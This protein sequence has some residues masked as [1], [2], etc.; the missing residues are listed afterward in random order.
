[1]GHRPRI[2]ICEPDT[3]LSEQ[4]FR[5]LDAA[6]FWV[7][8]V[9]S[10][11]QALQV[12]A[13]RRYQALV[14]GLLHRD[15]DGLSFSHELRMLGVQV[16][17]LLISDGTHPSEAPAWPRG[18]E[19]CRG[20]AGIARQRD[21]DWVRKAA[22]QARTLFAVKSVCRRHRGFRPR[23]LHVEADGFSADL[24]KA[25]LRD[26]VHLIRAGDATALDAALKIPAYDFAL[27]NPSL[28]DLGAEAIFQRIVALCPGTPVVTRVHSALWR[29]TPSLPGNAPR[30][31]AHDFVTA[32]R[33]LLL[34]NMQMPWRAQA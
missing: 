12:L 23:I 19:D 8:L 34:H 16:P 20:T 31:D 29:E 6:G 4:L 9:E 2:L 14:L 30:A 18:P 32:L 26:N 7:H 27:I 21:I 10:T 13:D 17:I 15:Q 28:P 24:L 22:D 11:R 1:M 5:T 25:V 3:L 33:T